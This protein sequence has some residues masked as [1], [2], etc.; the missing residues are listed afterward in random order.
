MRRIEE[1]DRRGPTIN[2]VIELNPDALEIADALDKERKAKGPRGPLHGIP[3]LIKDNI[4]TADRMATTA[5]VRSPWS[6]RENPRRDGFCRGTAATGRQPSSSAKRTSANGGNIRSTSSVSGWSARGGLTRN[7]YAL[8]R[9]TSGSSA[10]SA[11]AVAASL[12]AVALGTETDGSIVS[13]SSVNGIVGLKPTVGLISRSGIV[14]LSHTQDTSGPMGRTV[15]DVAT[16]LG[17]LTGADPDDAATKETA[18]KAFTDYTPF[19][20]V[21]GLRGAR[22]GVVRSFFGFSKAVDAVM[23]D[24]LRTMAAQGANVIDVEVPTLGKFENMEMTVFLYELKAN[25]N[26]YLEKLG[27]TAPV[28]SLK[29]IIDFNRRY[30]TKEMP[31]FGQNLFIR[32][33]SKGSLTSQEYLDA[34]ETCRRLSRQEGIDAVMD[35]HRLEALAAPTGGPAWVTDL[36]HGGGGAGGSSSLAAVAGYPNITVPAGSVTGLPVGISFFGRAW[37]EAVSASVGLFV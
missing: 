18:E 13:P 36:V 17:P 34:L 2:C 14:P 29:E 25:L 32:A 31:Y 9:N 7:P 26:G 33:E 28:H 11:A 15:R 30:K 8:D 19:L 1:I 16:L 22:I 35:R 5:V 4:D 23:E 6:A 24:A 37:S 20:D 12:C 21:H 10:G 27:P 3:V